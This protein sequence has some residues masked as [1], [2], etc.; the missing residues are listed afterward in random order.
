MSKS[1]HY[2]YGVGGIASPTVGHGG[3][4]EEIPSIKE[5]H[6]KAVLM[7]CLVARLIA[8]SSLNHMIIATVSGLVL[9][10]ANAVPIGCNGCGTATVREECRDIR[11]IIPVHQVRRA[12]GI[13]CS[14]RRPPHSYRSQVRC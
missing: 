14:L 5:N 12:H 8:S 9:P 10:A 3:H 1:D 7:A 2:K 6:P 4:G 11:G 13:W